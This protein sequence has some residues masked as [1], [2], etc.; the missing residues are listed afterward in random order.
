M[1]KK[2]NGRSGKL[3]GLKKIVLAMKFCLFFLLI[4][5]LSVSAKTFSQNVKLSMD[6]KDASII[7]VLM[8]ISRKTDMQLLYNDNELQG[9]FVN[10]SFKNAT[11]TE[12]LDKVF[13]G[14]ALKYSI[15]DGVIVVSPKE[16]F[17][18]Q[19]IKM[20]TIKGQV[21]DKAGNPLPGATVR[22]KD[23]QLGVVTDLHGKFKM[24]IAD[25]KDLTIVVSFIGFKTLSIKPTAQTELNIVLEE[26]LLGM[27]EV[28]V[29][30]YFNKAKSSY[31]GSAVTVKADELRKISPTNLFK[32]LQAYE[33]SLQIV[34]NNEAGSD[35][36]KVPE[37]LIRGKSS[38]EGKSNNPLFIMDGY[39]V[40][41][42]K[43]FDF[44]ME[45]IKQIT[46]LKD[47]SA[48]AIYGSRASNGVIVIETKMPE[49][50]KLTAS[51]SFNGTIEIPDLTD[52]DL[53]NARE[54]LDFEVRAKV[55]DA[56]G[57]LEE[58]MKL[59]RLYEARHKEVER[60]VNTYWLS[61]PLRTAFKHTHSL[62]L[63]GG[64]EN[65]R[66]GINVNY[67][68]NPGVMKGSRRDRL[69]ISFTWNYSISDKL[70]IGNSLSVNQNTTEESP[71]GNYSQYTSVNPYER[72]YDDMGR[73]IKKLSNGR[74][75]PVFDATLNNINKSKNTS[76]NDNFDVEW[77]I[78]EGLRLTG[79]FAYTYGATNTDVFISPKSSSFNENMKLE[80]KGSY[81]VSS[82]LSQSMDGNIVLNGWKT[83]DKHIFT[84]VVG[85]NLQ[86]NQDE[87]K[88]FHTTGFLSDNLTNLD[89]AMKYKEG[90][91]PRGKTQED[92]MIG[93]FANAS[94]SFDN[95]YMA[96]FSYRTDGS[97]KFGKENRFA[98]FWSAG[99]G[100]NIHNEKFWGNSGWLTQAKIR[101][102]IGYT[103]NVS[104]SPYQ[105]QTTY[106]YSADNIYINGV[107][108]D[109]MA[110]GND[111]LKWQRKLTL[112]IGGDFDFYEGLFAL[113]AEY[114]HEYTKD[115][116]I[117][118]S[119]PPSLGF[120][121]YKENL[122]EMENM[123]WSL[124]LRTQILRDYDREL[125]W[126]LSFGTSDSWNKIKKISNK[127]G[128]MNDELNK[129]ETT[130]VVPL[131]EEGESTDAL[132]AVP[133]LGI[134]PETGREVFRKKDGTLTTVWDYND[135]IV[136]GTSDPKFR[137]NLNSFLTFKGMSLNMSFNFQ[138]G[139]QT[140]NQT[141]ASRVEGVNPNNNC[142]RRVLYDR[143]K[144]PGD[145][146]FFKNIALEE[147]IP[148]LTT[149]F[150]QDYNY[151]QIGSLSL[152]YEMK[153]N[154]CKKFGFSGLRLN[155]N[156]GDVARFSSVKEERGLS[157]PFAR[158]FTFSLSASL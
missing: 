4:S 135:K 145:R 35:P 45:R 34:E 139:G 102:S 93:L 149:R 67:G 52:Y 23:S 104:F 61:Q 40:D 128:A 27:D 22:I 12:I 141:L 107:G 75:N 82:S 51:Y 101:S 20:V 14:V 78:V 84:L 134:D 130:K 155:F 53:L 154:I 148:G 147:N 124:N 25:I 157:Y 96:D 42:Q 118:V 43:V 87:S 142:D 15:L 39:E 60:G 90:S 68:T 99:I 81:D 112:N 16:K 31:T 92:R 137:G 6:K 48:T 54:K 150:V 91:K 18:S 103:G 28:V 125:F 123:G 17:V 65:S 95:R 74:A 33:P 111:E 55:Y 10:V 13:N 37:I 30:G 108:A 5:F 120:V 89:F 73:C 49:K 153:Q 9:V 7:E 38:F 133:S 32:A 59:D 77:Y 126:S 136:C 8:E 50:G 152:G 127:L 117:D 121:D 116:L 86:G 44:D 62:Y 24:E 106:L 138:Y 56:K 85:A 11:V 76:Y 72:A 94:Y 79:R 46:I 2:R 97:S 80:D 66:Y 151:F 58:Q 140:Y 98:P 156:I 41:M 105:A 115:M 129:N 57:D 144:K 19:T 109:I 71:Y 100:W 88:E 70:R 64:N 63:G 29:T 47:A 113:T 131:Y 3:P 69:G 114:F 122:G 132:K 21:K 158:S 146:T 119:L 36:N 110:L 83:I 26:E 143:W 1:K